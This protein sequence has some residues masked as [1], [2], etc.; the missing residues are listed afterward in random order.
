MELL[1]FSYW[2]HQAIKGV[3][4]FW[5]R[6]KCSCNI[7]VDSSLFFW[8]I[9]QFVTHSYF[10]HMILR[11][12]L[13]K[14]FNKRIC[15]ERMFFW[16]LKALSL[17]HWNTRLVSNGVSHTSWG[18]GAPL[19][20]VGHLSSDGITIKI[21][22]GVFLLRYHIISYCQISWNL[23]REMNAGGSCD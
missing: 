13:K 14:Q 6:W 16:Q 21:S 12:M 11:E 1:T 20:L 8:V 9:F 3:L 15:E 22:Y 10:L 19:D 18:E 7:F 4:K 23:L 5:V 2:I 17:R